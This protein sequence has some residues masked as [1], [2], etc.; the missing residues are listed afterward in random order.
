MDTSTST[1]KPY[2]LPTGRRERLLIL[3]DDGDDCFLLERALA[4]TGWNGAFYTVH[5]GMEAVEYLTGIGKYED[6]EKYPYPTTIFVDLKMPRMNGLQFLQ[7]IKEHSEHRVVPTIVLTASD[8]ARDV[9]CAYASGATS[10]MV[11][12]G[13]YKELESLVDMIQ[14]YWT[15]CRRPEM[16]PSNLV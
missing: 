8:H 12:P 3:E 11:K 9:Q 2:G 16:C 10:Y 13:S 7:W 4:R 5:D 1:A 15:T 6:R 14:R